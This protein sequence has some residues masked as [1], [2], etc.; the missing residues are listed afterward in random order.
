[1]AYGNIVRSA[2]DALVER[3]KGPTGLPYTVPAVARRENRTL[4]EI[5]PER[6]FCRFAPAD[7]VEKTSS[8]KYPTVQVGFE[9]VSNN[10]KAKFCR[11]SGTARLFI[12]VRLFGTRLQLLGEELELYVD[13]VIEALDGSRGDWGGG[14][15]YGGGYEVTAAPLKQA[16]GGYLQSARVVV[17]LDV[18]ID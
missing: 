1:M 17:D 15:Q 11:F 9:K 14:M 18:S 16:A 10:F 13:A 6:I 4:T 8:D 12:E 2:T 5:P 3:L 7:V